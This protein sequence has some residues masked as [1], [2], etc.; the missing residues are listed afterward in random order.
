MDQGV[1]SMKV[2]G[3]RT[4]LIPPRLGYGPMDMGKIPPN[5]ELKFEIELQNIQ[6]GPGAKIAM[7]LDGLR[8]QFGANPFT[9]FTVLFFLCFLA[10]V[11]LPDSSPLMFGDKANSL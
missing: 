3:K 8:S 1:A 9:F 2:G 10:P 4:L 11:L 7:F 5:S 6:S